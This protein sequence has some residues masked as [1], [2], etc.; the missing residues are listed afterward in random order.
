[1]LYTLLRKCLKMLREYDQQLIDAGQ[2]ESDE[3]LKIDKLIRDVEHQF[4]LK[5]K[6]LNK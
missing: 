5:G 6:P 3:K 2:G 1:M 4:I